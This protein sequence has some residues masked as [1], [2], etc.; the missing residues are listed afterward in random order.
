MVSWQWANF[1]VLQS[2]PRQMNTKADSLA[3]FASLLLPH[4]EF[5]DKKYQVEIVYRAYV[6]NNEESWKVFKNDKSIQLFLEND[7]VIYKDQPNK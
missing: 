4:P 1:G 6:P 5:K 2:V 7:K 3:I